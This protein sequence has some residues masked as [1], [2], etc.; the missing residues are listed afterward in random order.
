[1]LKNENAPLSEIRE[2]V[3]RTAIKTQISRDKN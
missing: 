1:M 3:I 2:S